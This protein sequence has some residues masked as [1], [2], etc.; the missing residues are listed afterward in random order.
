MV[1]MSGRFGWR[2]RAAVLGVV[3]LSASM[4]ACSGRVF[5]RVYE[6]EEAVYLSLDGTADVIV[7]ASIPALIALRGLDLDP[8]PAS[9]F[10]RD[11]VRAAYTSAVSEVTRVSRPWRRQGRRFVQVRIRVSD[12]RKLSQAPPFAWSTYELTEK[13][14]QIVY[15]QKVGPSA[16]KPGTLKN[17]G[18]SGGELVAF[19]IHLPS[20]IQWHNAREL[21][22]NETSEI[23]RGNIL[24]WEQLLT[25]RLDG[26]PVAIEVR[27]DR[28]SILYRTLWLFAGAFVAAVLVIAGL[29]LW[30]MR[31]GAAESEA[32]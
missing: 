30:T 23:A 10:D 32:A 27:M 14:G 6:Y 7:N 12:I 8:D 3:L 16:L 31:K 19:R 25:D 13:D 1:L 28:Q 15:R 20:R 26:Q 22:T 24:S 9:R 29:I 11:R 2:A 17:M 18:W 4:A 21:D 5:G